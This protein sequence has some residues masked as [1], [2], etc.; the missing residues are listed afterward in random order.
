MNFLHVFRRKVTFSL[1]FFAKNANNGPPFITVTV[2]GRWL[3]PQIQTHLLALW[4]LFFASERSKIKT[5]NTEING[6]GNPTEI[7]SN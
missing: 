3:K 5:V 7:I 2:R 6:N 1:L 4:H